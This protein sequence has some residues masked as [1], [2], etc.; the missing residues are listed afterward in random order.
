MGPAG[1]RRRWRGSAC[2]ARRRRGGPGPPPPRV[3]SGA[4]HRQVGPVEP[5]RLVVVRGVPKAGACPEPGPL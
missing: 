2:P 1:K 4:P 3:R 5:M